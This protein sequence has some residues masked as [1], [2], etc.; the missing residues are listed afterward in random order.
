M[1]HVSR[2]SRS[3]SMTT[4]DPVRSVRVDWVDRPVLVRPDPVSSKVPPDLNLL[5][6]GQRP[7][8]YRCAISSFSNMAINPLEQPQQLIY[9][10][11]NRL[12][13]KDDTLEAISVR[14]GIVIVMSP[15]TRFWEGRYPC[16]RYYWIIPHG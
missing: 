14:V 12:V 10:D 7:Y 3:Q 15:A 5:L 6:C 13:V 1:T 11:G 8:C 9:L 16:S 4:G 2:E